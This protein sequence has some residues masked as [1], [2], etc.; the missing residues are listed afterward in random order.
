L[1]RDPLDRFIACLVTIPRDR[2]NTENRERVGQILLETFGGSHLDWGLQLSE[3]VLAR[4]HYVIHTPDGVP[5]G[6]DLA[7]IEGRLIKA[8][9]AWTDDLRAALIAEHGEQRG[10]RLYRRYE[11][12][13][14]PGYRSDWVARS[15]VGDIARIEQLREGGGPIIVL[16]RPLEADRDVVRCK[17]FSE[18]EISLSDVLPTFENMGAKVADERPYEIVPEEAPAA[19]IYDFGLRCVAEDLEQVRELFQDAFLAVWRGELE[20]D[21]LNALV[22]RAVLTGRE[23]TIIRAIARYLRQ[24]GIAQ[25]DAYME[26]TLLAHSDIAALLVQLF[27]VRFDP[28]G[29]DIGAIERLTGEIEQAIEGVQS[30]YE[31]RI[32]RSFLS[33]VL[34]LLRTSYFRSDEEGQLRPYLS[35][36]VDPAKVPI[37][38]L[39]RPK[40]EIFVYSPRFE[41][42]HL[43]GGKVARGGLRW[44]DRLEDFRTEIL[45]LMK[46]QMVKNALIVPVGSKG[47][48]VLK[49]PPSE[50]G[51]EALVDEAIACYK[52]FLAGLLDLTDNIV[53]GAVVAPERVIRYDDDDPYLVVAADK[54]TASFSDIANGVSAAYG[55]WLGDAFASGGSHGYDHKQMGITARGAWESVKR[56]F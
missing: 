18:H 21:G 20:D 35:F 30:L 6:L 39:P 11:K 55:F 27:F 12:A 8:T 13:F 50:G 1:R 3:S 5:P 46:A 36:K 25:S 10:L 47:G 45:G 53:G 44:S 32:L 41:G 24:G 28:S 49:R 7:E 37:L 52:L 56:H 4:V 9:R 33:V 26:R 15:A 22:M 19:W 42:V 17:L 48:F 14:P 38:P 31:D 23:V 40:Y 34:A 29:P 43:R 2:F 16:Y 54:G 51:R